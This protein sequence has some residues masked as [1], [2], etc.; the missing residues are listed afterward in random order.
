MKKKQSRTKRIDFSEDIHAQYYTPWSESED[1]VLLN[2]LQHQ[3][4]LS[5]KVLAYRAASRLRQLNLHRTICA[6]EMRLRRHLR[7]EI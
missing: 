6:C 4:H 1:V 2:L 3:S 5:L 7:K